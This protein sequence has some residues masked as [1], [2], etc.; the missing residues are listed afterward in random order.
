MRYL[1]LFFSIILFSCGSGWTNEEKEKF[2][3]ECQKG[4]ASGSPN[5]S[6]AYCNCMLDKVTAR[7]ESPQAFA[8]ADDMDIP[9]LAT[10]CNDSILGAEVYWPNKTEEIFLMGCNEVIKMENPTVNGS[11]VCKCILEKV[12][13]RYPRVK[14]VNAINQDSMNVIKEECLSLTKPQ[15]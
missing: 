15:S 8:E 5:Y 7:F 13:V 9:E 4:V 10:A 12:K 6:R 1:L 11:Q 2:V 3:A 14:S